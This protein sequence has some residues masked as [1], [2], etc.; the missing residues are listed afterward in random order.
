MLEAG[1]GISVERFQEDWSGKGRKGSNAHIYS[2]V[3]QQVL[4]AVGYTVTKTTV[5]VE[6]VLYDKPIPCPLLGRDIEPGECAGSL[7]ISEVETREGVT[8]RG[9][10]D[11][12]LYWPGE[13]GEQMRWAVDGRPVAR[14]TMEREDN[15]HATAACLF[16]RIPDVIAAPPGIV[17]CSQLGPMKHTALQR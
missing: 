17:T 13:V 8:G 15:A 7:A 9:E 11:A 6:P 1:V 3:L 2:T 10:N 14:I 5:R 4:A 12:R 16:N